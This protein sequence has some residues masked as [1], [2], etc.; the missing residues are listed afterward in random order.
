VKAAQ[1]GPYEYA[2]RIRSPTFVAEIEDGG[3][4]KASGEE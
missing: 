3:L 2:A 1:Y 4:I